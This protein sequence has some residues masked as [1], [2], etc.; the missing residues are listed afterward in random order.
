[1]SFRLDCRGF[2]RRTASSLQT[3]EVMTLSCQL[4]I[5]SIPHVPAV[6]MLLTAFSLCFARL[7]MLQL[8]LGGKNEQ[9]N[10]VLGFSHE[11][12]LEELH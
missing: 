6:K 12:N 11:K 7:G 4:T 1:M 8:V 3:A 9:E 5:R 10:R 2:P